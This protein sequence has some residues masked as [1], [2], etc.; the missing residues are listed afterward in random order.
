MLDFVAKQQA[1]LE[2]GVSQLIRVTRKLPT[3]SL[4]LGGLGRRWR[5]EEFGIRQ[6]FAW[7]WQ[8]GWLAAGAAD[9]P[10]AAESA[11]DLDQPQGNLAAC[12]GQGV[13]EQHQVLL[14]LRDAGEVDRAGLVL[15]QA[16]LDGL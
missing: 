7:Q 12:L 4:E 9:L 11:I 13:L 8:R 16:D 1:M 6:R 15:V 3:R 10:A 14:K 2:M 5:R